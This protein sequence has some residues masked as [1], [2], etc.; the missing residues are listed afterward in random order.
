MHTGEQPPDDHKGSERA[1]GHKHGAA[2]GYVANTAFQLHHGGW[3]HTQRKHRRRGWI[4]SLQIAV[5]QY[6]AVIDGDFLK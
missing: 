4:R 6:G 1:E 2:N 5:D 3:K